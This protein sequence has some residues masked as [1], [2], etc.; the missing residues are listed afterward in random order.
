L[1]EDKR[2]IDGQ[3]SG[4]RSEYVSNECEEDAADSIKVTA[5]CIAR[6]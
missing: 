5:R 6:V 1:G 3:F 4:D 2:G